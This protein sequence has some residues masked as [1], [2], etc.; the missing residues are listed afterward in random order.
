MAPGG[1]EGKSPLD[2]HRLC[3]VISGRGQ[4]GREKRDRVERG[5]KVEQAAMMKCLE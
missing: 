4:G 2:T 3:G 5:M 1:A